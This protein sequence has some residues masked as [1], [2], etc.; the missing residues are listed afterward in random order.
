MSVAAEKPTS[1]VYHFYHD[2]P[3]RTLTVWVDDKIEVEF[4][5]S[6]LAREVFEQ[7]Q[8]AGEDRDVTFTLVDRQISWKR[9]GY[10]V[11]F[12]EVVDATIRVL[13][14]REQAHDRLVRQVNELGDYFSDKLREA[15]LTDE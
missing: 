3:V 13:K 4:H 2:F 7:L 8:K 12:E 11:F 5:D 15:G 14:E 10:D 9:D 6:E 1:A